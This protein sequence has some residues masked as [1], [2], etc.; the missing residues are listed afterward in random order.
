MRRAVLP[1]AVIAGRIL[2]ALITKCSEV[3]FG[4]IEPVFGSPTS[5]F[6]HSFHPDL[7]SSPRLRAP[8]LHRTRKSI[9]TLGLSLT[10][11]APTIHPP[12]WST[13]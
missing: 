13:C 2:A 5:V 4:T 3:P 6:S 7:N 9:S 12:W 8:F 11:A 1:A 10:A